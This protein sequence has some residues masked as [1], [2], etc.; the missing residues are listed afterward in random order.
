MY[1]GT[2]KYAMR[3]ETVV[4][5]GGGE[6]VGGTHAIDPTIKDAPPS[7]ANHLEGRWA[8]LTRP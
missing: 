7:F 4:D 3:G 2:A 1:E 5:I 6:K 8:E